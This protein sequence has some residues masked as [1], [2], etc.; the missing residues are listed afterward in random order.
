MDFKPAGLL[1]GIGSV[2]YTDSDQALSL[3][4]SNTPEIPYWPQMPQKGSQEGFVF[5][6]LSPLVNTGLITIENNRAFF[7]TENHRWA[8]GLAEFYTLY[9]AAVEGDAGALEAFSLQEKAASGFYAFIKYVE[10]KGPKEAIFFKGHLAGP[11]TIGFQLKDDKGRLAY[12]EDQ[13]R[14]VLVK[15]LALHGRWQ[16]QKLSSLGRPAIIFV[17]EP[18]ISVY[19]KSGYITVTREMIERDLNEISDQIHAA[20]AL[21]GVHSC[22][23]IDWSIL[24]QCRLDIV[25]LDAYNF[26]ESL[27]PFARELKDFIQ[28]GGILA[29]G[30]VPTNEK[31]FDENCES[32]VKR[33]QDLWDQLLIRGIPQRDLLMRTMITPAC[34]TGLL[35]PALAVHIYSLAREVSGAVRELARG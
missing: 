34:G 20:G 8:E 24:Y 10:E 30:I 14:D 17:D 26:G 5:Q 27:L 31:A 4:F 16:A 7:D 13:L 15:T 19:G 22:D 21:S 28:R 3:I 35:D 33:L 25:N 6:F 32:L 23:A 18:G 9:M 11:L 29:Q 12:Y 2:P 1:T